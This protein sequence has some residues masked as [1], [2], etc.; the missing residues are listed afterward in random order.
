MQELD[1]EGLINAFEQ[2]IIIFS[3]HIEPFAY[4]MAQRLVH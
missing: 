3:D 4:E 1:H 2:I